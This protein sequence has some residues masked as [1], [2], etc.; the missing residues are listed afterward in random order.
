MTLNKIVKRELEVAFSRKTQPIWMR[1]IKYILIL[2]LGYFL[3][4][5][6]WFWITFTSLLFVSL[7]VHFFY[8]Y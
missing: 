2:A 4:R 5:T 7:C 6:H 3:W 1:I 8:R